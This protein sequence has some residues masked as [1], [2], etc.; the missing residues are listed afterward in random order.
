MIPNRCLFICLA[1]MEFS[2]VNFLA[3]R[4]AATVN[5]PG[6]LVVYY[7]R[8]PSGRWWDAA[9][10]YVTD[11]VQVDPPTSVGG[12]PLLHPAHRA[13]L[14]RLELLQADGGVYLDLDVVCAKP[15]TPLLGERFVLGRE[16]DDGQDLLC[17]GVI[18][19]EPDSAFTREW[20]KGF[21]P[22]TSLWS[23]FR[24]RGVDENWNEMGV[25]YPCHLARLYPDLITVAAH[26]AFHYP[27]WQ[28]DDLDLLFRRSGVEFPNAY[29]HHLWQ[30][31]S[32]DRYLKDLTPA[33]IKQVDTNFTRIVRRYVR[34][35]RD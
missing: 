26:D 18:L 30:N 29:C 14:L 11:A 13:D 6:E 7:D 16:G 34:D 31:M 17:N 20:I 35:I 3:V 19:A 15:L 24:S 22:A 12:V 28:D 10:E 5:E 21:D 9:S 1:P 27:T 8:K 33:Y 2:L 32:W 23:G 4:S 25:Q